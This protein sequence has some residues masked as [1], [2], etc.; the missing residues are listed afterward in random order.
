[1]SALAAAESL[2][3]EE[4]RRQ[5]SEKAVWMARISEAEAAL[6]AMKSVDTV[7]VA[8]EVNEMSCVPHQVC[9]GDWPFGFHACQHA[10]VCT[11]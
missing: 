1:M 11:G 6:Q 2:V 3:R 4:V 7:K 9:R 5:Q 10:S 8:C